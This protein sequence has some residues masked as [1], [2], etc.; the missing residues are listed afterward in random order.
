MLKQMMEDNFFLAL[1]LLSV[2]GLVL[3]IVCV[4]FIALL[5]ALINS[6]G[7]LFSV[8]SGGYG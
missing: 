2:M 1:L 3:G 7:L 4:Y 5:I 8:L 6:F